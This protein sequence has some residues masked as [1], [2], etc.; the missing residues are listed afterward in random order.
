MNKILTDMNERAP[1]GQGMAPPPP[2]GIIDLH[3]LSLEIFMELI[4]GRELFGED[5]SQQTYQKIK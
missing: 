3:E 4:R 2:N 1:R 5:K